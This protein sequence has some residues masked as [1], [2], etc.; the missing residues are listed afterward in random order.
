MHNKEYALKMLDNLKHVRIFSR[1]AVDVLVG[2][3]M[4][5]EDK[6]IQKK[7][8]EVFKYL[9]RA[10]R[11]SASKV[12]KLLTE[13]FPAMVGK[14]SKTK[15]KSKKRAIKSGPSPVGPFLGVYN[16]D[17]PVLLD[18]SR[19]GKEWLEKLSNAS[20]EEREEMLKPHVEASDG[21]KA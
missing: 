9:V 21:L 13:H 4:M 2:V 6:D 14:R 10:R 5:S 8:K 17:K 18:Y 20:R 15:A 19:M 1:N 3:S 7:V 11:I 16:L 12:E